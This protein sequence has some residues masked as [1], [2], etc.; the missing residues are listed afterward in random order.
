MTANGRT[1]LL[2]AEKIYECFIAAVHDLG[3]SFPF[4]FYEHREDW[5]K[6][7]EI[8]KDINADPARLVKAQFDS[9]SGY[10]KLQ[11][12]PVDMWKPNHRV[13]DLYHIHNPKLTAVNYKDMYVKLMKKMKYYT[14][15]RKCSDVD[16]MRDMNMPFPA[17]FRVTMAPADPHVLEVYGETAV[18]EYQTQKELRDFTQEISRNE[19]SRFAEYA[20]RADDVRL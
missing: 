13:V 7:A 18:Y 17:W 8:C 16:L 1:T 9:L 3:G 4:D 10:R 12:R 15:V 5:I 6:S 19:L 11:L 14:K 20:E 2:L